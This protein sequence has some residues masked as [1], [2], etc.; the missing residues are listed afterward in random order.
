MSTDKLN[1]VEIAPVE[2]DPLF[3][4]K[5]D[6]FLAS[7]GYGLNLKSLKSMIKGCTMCGLRYRCNSPV[8]P[9]LVPESPYLFV[10]RNPTQVDDEKGVLYAKESPYTSYFRRY[11]EE[12]REDI[13]AVSTSSSFFCYS[14]RGFEVGRIP[15]SC[16][17]W[18]TL[19]YDFLPNLQVVFLMGNRILRRYQGSRVTNIAKEM[20]NIYT[21][22][23]HGRKVYM[24]PIV[25]PIHL[26][27]NPEY[28]DLVRAMIGLGYKIVNKEFDPESL[29]SN[30][31]L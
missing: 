3:K 31:V 1:L 19:E 21:T 16:M 2:P 20:G 7:R 10:G 15:A 23:I 9:N 25:S 4:S 17:K 27:Q 11:V 26:F 30:N 5:V 18:K 8:P 13:K 22:T 12:L 24:I 29:R 28:N 6:S 14:K